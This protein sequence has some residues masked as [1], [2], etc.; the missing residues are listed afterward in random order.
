M[1]LDKKGNEQGYKDY[2]NTLSTII[3]NTLP[4][5]LGVDVNQT[6]LTNT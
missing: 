6:Q 2:T 1:G 3:F 5:K 4:L